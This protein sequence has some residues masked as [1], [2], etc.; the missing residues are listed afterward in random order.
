M[1]EAATDALDRWLGALGSLL[2]ADVAATADGWEL[3]GAAEGW[4]RFVGNLLSPPEREGTQDREPA[5]LAVASAPAGCE[6]WRDR[7]RLVEKSAA[8]ALTNAPVG[9][10]ALLP[11][12]PKGAAGTTAARLAFGL[13]LSLGHRLRRRYTAYVLLG[14]GRSF[15]RR[16]ADAVLTQLSKVGPLDLT[17]RETRGALE[18]LLAA[19]RE[20]EAAYREDPEVVA[21]LE[22]LRERYKE[23]L[24]CLDRLY[25]ANWGQDA[26][27]LGVPAAGLKGDDAIEAEYVSRLEDL[28]DRYRP[29]VVFE[30]L[31]LG[32]VEGWSEAEFLS[33]AG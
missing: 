11:T 20:A 14:E 10:T 18:G 26:P 28:A 15:F 30:P 23:E 8:Q 12:A 3:S 33:G 32:L 7:L 4:V 5:L 6:Q 1:S 21:E 25:T 31:T 2:E 13:S 9:F 17:R 29:R 16:G 19:A 24:R 22:R 27:L